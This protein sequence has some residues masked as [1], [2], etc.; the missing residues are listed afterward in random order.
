MEKVVIISILGLLAAL[1]GVG[2][3]ISSAPQSF[4]L[5]AEITKY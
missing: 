4:S 1:A 3:K 2:Y 5:S